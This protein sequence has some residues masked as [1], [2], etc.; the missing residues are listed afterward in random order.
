MKR[1][2]ISAWLDRNARGWL[3]LLLLGLALLFNLVILPAGMTWL[4][5]AELEAGPIDLTFAAAPPV[6]FEMV[7]SYG[8]AG[9]AAYRLSSLTVDV[10]YPI[11]YST[12]LA[13]AITYFF[14][15]ALPSQSR[16]QAFNRLPFAVL[17][18]DILEN[19]GIAGLLTTYPQQLTW[20]AGL[21]VAMN[22]IKWLLAGASVAL[23]LS[24]ILLLAFRLPSR[25]GKVS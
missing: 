19:L 24:G 5:G 17:A 6:I 11:V 4:G 8:D 7:A 3:I 21:T 9:R 14:R 10:V 22:V 20:L 18:F 13:L 15:R 16:W 2:P 12:C 25:K 1:D 23:A